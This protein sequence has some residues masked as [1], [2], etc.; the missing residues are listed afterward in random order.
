[1][2]KTP[3]HRLEELV[4]KYQKP[5]ETTKNQENFLQALNSIPTLVQHFENSLSP[6]VAARTLETL[7]RIRNI[8]EPLPEKGRKEMI[9]E[10]QK[11][12][13]ER[14][15]E[16]AWEDF[17]WTDPR[18]HEDNAPNAHTRI[19]ITPDQVFFGTN[20]LSP[21]DATRTQIIHLVAIYGLRSEMIIAMSRAL[22]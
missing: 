3:S 15:K 11:T 16:H 4:H 1:M 17:D 18:Q 22:S 14:W 7:N 12:A 6:E 21:D 2:D 9:S 10:A 5:Q 8:L 13:K 20:K 19:G